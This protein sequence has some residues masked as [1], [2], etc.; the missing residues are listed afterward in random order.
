MNIAKY[1]TL[2]LSGA[3]IAVCAVTAAHSAAKKANTWSLSLYQIDDQMD[4]YLNGTKLS[5]C[6]FGNTCNSDLTNLMKSG[7]NSLKLV[8]T[9]TGAGWTYGYQILKNGSVYKQDS[10]GVFNTFGCANDDYTLGEVFSVTY[11]ITK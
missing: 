3:V 10:C 11:A 2:A 1:T 8:L 7:K 4:V 5:T 9:N 6:Y